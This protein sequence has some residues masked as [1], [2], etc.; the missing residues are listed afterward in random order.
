MN[1]ARRKPC[2]CRNKAEI[3]KDADVS[4]AHREGGAEFLHTGEYFQQENNCTCHLSRQFLGDLR[5]L[6]QFV[7]FWKKPAKSE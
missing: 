1:A 3:L 7:S 2:L 4:S 5:S 6:V